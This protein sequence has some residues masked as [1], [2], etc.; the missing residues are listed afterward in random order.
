M[1]VLNCVQL[2][3]LVDATKCLDLHDFSAQVKLMIHYF[4]SFF[5]IG[6]KFVVRRAISTLHFADNGG[7]SLQCGEP[8]G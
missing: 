4:L 6:M 8:S 7:I 3:L 1:D 2:I 5:S